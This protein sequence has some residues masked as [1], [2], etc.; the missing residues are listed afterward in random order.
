MK[1]K[2]SV[3]SCSG[4]N[5]EEVR[6]KAGGVNEACRRQD[7]IKTGQCCILS[8]FGFFP[9]AFPPRGKCNTAV[10]SICQL[11]RHTHWESQLF[12]K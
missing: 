11:N 1:L 8:H 5:E 4:T 2:Y 9:H 6:I 12:L 3:T 10:V 7:C